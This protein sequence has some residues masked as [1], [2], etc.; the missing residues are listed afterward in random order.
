M[1]VVANM[2]VTIKNGGRATKETVA[3]PYSKFKHAIADCLVKEGYLEKASKKTEKAG[4]A[5]LEIGLKY[6]NGKPK[7]DNLKRMS[8]PSRRLYLGA[9]DIRPVRNG[10]GLLVLSTPKGIL[11][12]DDARKELVGGEVLFKLW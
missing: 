8:K 10:Y 1:D 7:V 4:H 5:I 11:S 9:R 2:M 6:E 3:V 12:G